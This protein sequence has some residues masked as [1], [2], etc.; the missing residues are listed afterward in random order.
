MAECVGGVVVVGVGRDSGV[1]VVMVV[2]E[3][4]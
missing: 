3:E 4:D 1:E 2:V